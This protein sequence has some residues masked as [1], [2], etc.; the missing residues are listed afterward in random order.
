M[1]RVRLVSR[2]SSAGARR[3]K[4]F[5]RL[6]F[7]HRA[8]SESIS[9]RKCSSVTPSATVRTITPPAVLGQQLGDHLPQLGPL[10]PA[11]DLAA[12]ADLRGVR[13]VDE[14]PAREGDLRGDPAAL[15]ADRL[16]GDLDREGLTLLEDVLD[17]GEGAAGEISR[18]RP[19]RRASRGG[20]AVA[21]A[22][23][24]GDHG[25]ASRLPLRP[26][27]RPRLERRSARPPRLRGGVFLVVRL[28]VLV[29][30]EQIGRVEERALL[31][32]MST[33]AAWMPGSTASTRPR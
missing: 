25:R 3:T 5:F 32:P 10:L 13:H 21:A 23:A 12:D 1:P 33:N 7:F 17:V 6:I 18:C 2:W 31:L 27:P 20:A 29:G 19:R 26:A 8:S 22:A 14:E 4:V 16:L 15:G 30:L 9:R 24:G 28:L 11:L